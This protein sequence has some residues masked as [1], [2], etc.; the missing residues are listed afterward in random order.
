ML[1]A[2][3][4]LW[5]VAGMFGLPVTQQ[6]RGCPPTGGQPRGAHLAVA[7]EVANQVSPLPANDT[8]AEAPGRR[9]GLH[10]QPVVNGG[11]MDPDPKDPLKIIIVTSKLLTGLDAPI[12]QTM[13]LDKPLRDRTLLQAICRTNRPYRAILSDSFVAEFLPRW[14]D[15]P[16]D[17]MT[18]WGNRPDDDG[19][20]AELAIRANEVFESIAVIP[21]TCCPLGP[22]EW[23]TY[24]R[25]RYAL[26]EPVADH[27]GAEARS[28]RH[29]R[30]LVRIG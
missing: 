21:A 28:E 11:D 2:S 27:H 29:H 16:P 4:G 9:K 19:L 24:K 14:K 3:L 15:A 1:K 10:T 30:L 5:L 23:V 18:R 25:R 26:P 12:L 13:Y 17:Y 20:R 7:G 22:E 8:H 6:H